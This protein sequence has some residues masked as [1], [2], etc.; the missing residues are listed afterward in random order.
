ASCTSRS[1]SPTTTA[2]GACSITSAPCDLHGGAPRRGPPPAPAAAPPHGHRGGVG[3]G[4]P[5]G[6]GPAPRGRPHPAPPPRPA[7]PAPSGGPPLPV[8][9]SEDA[10][11]DA[12]ERAMDGAGFATAHVAGN[13][14][15]GY[16]ALQLAARGR[17]RSVVALAPAGGWAA[18]DES[19]HETLDHFA[20]M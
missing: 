10:F 8:P 4:G 14:L 18:G 20:R 5:A 17:A 19:Y 6:G 15:G 3:G 7:A 2:A 1:A 12:I 16:L 13:S 9:V 11:L